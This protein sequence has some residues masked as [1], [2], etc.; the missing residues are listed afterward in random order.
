MYWNKDVAAACGE[1]IIDVTLGEYQGDNMYVLKQGDSYA[2]LILGYGSCSYCDFMEGLYYDHGNDPDSYEK[3]YQEVVQETRDSIIWYSKPDFVE[4]LG[5]KDFSLGFY[6]WHE[7]SM[8]ELKD[9]IEKEFGI[10]IN[11]G[12]DDD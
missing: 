4:Y 9:A 2:L 12:E 8:K 7:S 5:E 1:I 6:S 10:E 11:I 3:A